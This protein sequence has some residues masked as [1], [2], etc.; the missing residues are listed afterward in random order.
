MIQF[1]GK[2]GLYCITTE[3]GVKIGITTNLTRRFKEHLTPMVKA[4][5]ISFLV[6]NVFPIEELRRVENMLKSHYSSFLVETSNEFFKGLDGF[7]VFNQAKGFLFKITS[8]RNRVKNHKTE[9]Q[10]LQYKPKPKYTTT[11]KI[12]KEALDDF[13]L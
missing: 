1:K 6:F 9:F 4:K 8:K 10:H 13:Y 7:D 12:T 3:E 5:S 2:T 11:S